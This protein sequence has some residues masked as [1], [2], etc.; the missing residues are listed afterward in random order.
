MA[1]SSWAPWKNL[2]ERVTTIGNV[3]IAGGDEVVNINRAPLTFF[4]WRMGTASRVEESGR[5][6]MRSPASWVATRVLRR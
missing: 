5:G 2:S 4:D 1:N 3:G 6:R